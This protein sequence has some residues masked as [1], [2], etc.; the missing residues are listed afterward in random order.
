MVTLTKA[1]VD[2]IQGPGQRRPTERFL[3]QQADGKTRAID[4]CGRTGHSAATILHETITTVN[5]DA[6][7]TFSR[8]VCDAL[9]LST[10]PADTHDWLDLSG[11]TDDLP[12]A[13]RGLPVAP[14]QMRFNYVA[15][16]VPGSDRFRLALYPPCLG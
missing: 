11:G 6:I 16:Y 4:N 7:A 9:C 12:D 5:I 13:Y 14:E 10:P 2:A 1:Q 15:I 8:M 3:I